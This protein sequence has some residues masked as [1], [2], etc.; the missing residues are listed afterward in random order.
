ML[1]AKSLCSARK[2]EPLTRG[3]IAV[4]D[5]PLVMPD[6]DA[7]IIGTGQTGP[8]FGGATGRGRLED[9]DHRTQA[10]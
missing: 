6:Y 4:G 2:A 7:I 1:L 9:R 3:K 10:Q 5:Q 8:P